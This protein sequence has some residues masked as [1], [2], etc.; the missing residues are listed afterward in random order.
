M[1]PMETLKMR[2]LGIVN[3]FIYNLF[4][5]RIIKMNKIEINDYSEQNIF[6]GFVLEL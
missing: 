3:Y 4:N 1:N 2:F 6:G 5:S